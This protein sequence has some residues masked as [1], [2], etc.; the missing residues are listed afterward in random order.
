MEVAAFLIQGAL[1]SGLLFSE[2]FAEDVSIPDKG[3]F[4]LFYSVT[5]LSTFAY[6]ILF[7]IFCLSSI[8][9]LLQIKF[10][11]DWATRIL[12]L[13]Y[14]KGVTIHPIRG[15]P[16]KPDIRHGS[17]EQG[18]HKTTIGRHDGVVAIRTIPK[19]GDQSALF[20]RTQLDGSNHR[21]SNFGPMMDQRSVG[22]PSLIKDDPKLPPFKEIISSA[23][24]VPSQKE[25]KRGENQRLVVSGAVIGPDD[26]PL[27]SAVVYLAD[28]DGNKVGQS[29]RSN[30]G[31]GFFKVLVNEAGTFL[32]HA[33]K[34]GYAMADDKPKPVPI[35]SGRVD[36]LV[37]KLVSQECLIKGQA[38]LQD[39]NLPLPDIEIKCVCRSKGFVRT[40]RTD[41]GGHFRLP[42]VPMNSECYLEAIDK[43]GNILVKTNGFETVQK[44]HL[45]KVIRIPVVQSVSD[46]DSSEVFNPFISKKTT[47]EETT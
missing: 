40:S 22:A 47:K 14:P 18:A 15:F 10:G 8:N 30:A 9:L 31:K 44:K 39:E 2:C 16:K 3:R 25:L 23:A 41:E 17:K 20:P 29:C 4:G 46:N 34:Q 19:D 1:I 45:Y 37:V 6:V 28:V 36:G 12:G 21:L 26:K 33:Y 38:V 13:L 5:H 35:Q 27:E 42:N 7:L 24:D 11:C 32:V 43:S